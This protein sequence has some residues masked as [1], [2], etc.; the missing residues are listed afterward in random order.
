MKH[1]MH[2]AELQAADG[3]VIGMPLG[4]PDAESRFLLGWHR[5]LWGDG[6]PNKNASWHSCCVAAWNLWT[7]PSDHL[8][9]F[10]ALQSRRCRL[11]GCC[12]P[13][14]LSHLYSRGPG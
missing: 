5:N 11:T 14:P 6:R 9:H 10:K 12:L 3:P 13:L 2:F 7:A 4:Y 8:R 1:I